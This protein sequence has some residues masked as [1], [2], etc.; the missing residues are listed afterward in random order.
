MLE[1]RP[2]SMCKV[3]N[4]H[5]RIGNAMCLRILRNKPG[6]NKISFSVGAA[7]LIDQLEERKSAIF[8]IPPDG[9]DG[10]AVERLSAGHHRDESRFFPVTWP[11]TLYDELHQHIK[12]KSGME[13]CL[14]SNI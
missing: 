4:R 11:G 12:Q 5:F 2:F 7:C 6:V 10:T 14:G 3:P 1:E 13:K 8:E 9:I